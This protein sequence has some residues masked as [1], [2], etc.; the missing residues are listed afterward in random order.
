MR[1]AARRGRVCAFES[2]TPLGHCRKY[3]RAD[4]VPQVIHTT[5]EISRA[6]LGKI[7]RHKLS[8]TIIA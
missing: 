8:E 4:E 1:P 6:G 7:I 5:G 2:D 3:P